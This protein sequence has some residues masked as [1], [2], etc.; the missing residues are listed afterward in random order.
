MYISECR[1]VDLQGSESS[2]NP[3]CTSEGFMGGVRIANGDT[4]YTGT[5]PNSE[6][7][8]FAQT[9]CDVG[10]ELSSE[11]EV[12][13]CQSDGTWSGSPAVCTELAASCEISMYFYHVCACAAR[14]E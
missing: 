1:E 14:V 7:P 6:P 13:N 4:C 3:M 12:R 10:Y 9:F 5:N 8:H 11:S 2:T